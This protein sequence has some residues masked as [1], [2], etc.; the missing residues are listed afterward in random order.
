MRLALLLLAITGCVDDRY[1]CT[2]DAQ[3]ETGFCRDYKCCNSDCGGGGANGNT[4]DCQAC[5]TAHYGQADGTCTTVLD[6]SYVCRLYVDR[7][8]DLSDRCDGTS[9]ACPPD[10]GQHAG[11]VCNTTTGAVCPP[12]TAGN[13]HSCPI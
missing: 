11:L 4:G 5:S 12:A 9:T 7:Y 6:T 3:C 13:S 2:T 10:L 1:R 8:C